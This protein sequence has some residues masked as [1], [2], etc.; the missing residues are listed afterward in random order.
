MSEKLSRPT[1]LIP[2]SNGETVPMNPTG[3]RAAARGEERSKVTTTYFDFEDI[4]PETGKPKMWRD[5]KWVSDEVLSDK[6]QDTL[7][8]ELA[9]ASPT[10]GERMD[11]IRRQ[12]VREELGSEAVEAAS[13]A[14]SEVTEDDDSFA[15]LWNTGPEVPFD[16]E[17][18]AV[19]EPVD[20]ADSSRRRRSAMDAKYNEVMQSTGDPAAAQAAADRVWNSN[21]F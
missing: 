10:Y 6:T 11:E 12:K 5:S 21:N 15:H 16:V 7:A 4:N 18:A 8:Q 19:R 1:Y 17:R 9:E 20:P 14:P 2:R 13:Q 3:A